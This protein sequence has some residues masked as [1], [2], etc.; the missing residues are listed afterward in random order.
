[1]IIKWVE[2]NFICDNCQKEAIHPNNEHRKKKAI[3]DL[4]NGRCCPEDSLK[5]WFIK[6]NKILCPKCK[7]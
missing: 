5:G 6:G 7:K 2:W 3:E 1:M 4:K